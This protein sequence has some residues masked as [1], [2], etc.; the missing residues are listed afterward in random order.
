MGNSAKLCGCRLIGEKSSKESS[1]RLS[2]AVEI[3]D[4][5]RFPSPPRRQFA[6][7]STLQFVGL[8][9]VVKD[10]LSVLIPRLE[11]T[12]NTCNRYVYMR[13]DFAPV[14]LKIQLNGLENLWKRKIVIAPCC[15]RCSSHIESTSHALFGCKLDR[16]VLLG[17]RFGSPLSKLKNCQVMEVFM[18]ITVVIGLDDL[19]LLCMISWAI[20]ES[21]NSSLKGGSSRDPDSVVSWESNL[22]AE[23]TTSQLA[24]STRS[25]VTFSNPFPDWVAPPPSLLKLNTGV[26]IRKNSLSIAAGAVIRDDKGRA[27]VARSI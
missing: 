2:S 26:A 21:R 23:F 18:N 19:K 17:T 1:C 12:I 14:A 3:V 10:P 8:S 6:A 27:L 22:L 24:Y 16:K 11:T 20:W 9:Q 25:S 15:S 13:L 4:N 5:C 7:V